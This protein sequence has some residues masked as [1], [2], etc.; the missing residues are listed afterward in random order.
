MTDKPSQSSGLAAA[1]SEEQRSSRI[2]GAL[3]DA[4]SGPFG[5]P[6]GA[7]A[8]ASVLE[9]ATALEYPSGT[10]VP[11]VSPHAPAGEYVGQ[12]TD[13]CLRHRGGLDTLA[14]ALGLLRENSPAARKLRLL[15]DQDAA[16]EVLPLEEL[17]E[18]EELL[19]QLPSRD[20]QAV[21]H[22]ALYAS[23]APL[24]AYCDTPWQTLLH[25]LRRNAL[26]TGLPAYMAFLEYL[27]AG[28]QSAAAQHIRDMNTSRAGQWR[29][30]EQ[31]EHCRNTAEPVSG[32]QRPPRV[33][34]ALMPDGLQDS[35]YILRAWH[36]RFGDETAGLLREPDVT[37]REE[38]IPSE[39][40]SRLRRLSQSSDSGPPVQVEFW[41]PMA[42]MNHRVEEWCRA[43]F[44][45]A[46]EPQCTVV[47]RSLDRARTADWRSRWQHRW[48]RFSQGTVEVEVLS[49]TSDP[50]AP[51]TSASVMVL[52]TPP[53]AE[54]GR[55]ELKRALEIGVPAVLWDRNDCAA[56]EFRHGVKELVQQSTLAELQERLNALRLAGNTS[57]WSSN[58][59][60]LWDDPNHPLPASAPLQDPAGAFLV[61]RGEGRR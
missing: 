16:A 21:A 35:H 1:W 25:L 27:T 41:L 18:L 37:V 3:V 38:A 49:E 58:L 31:L 56:P 39:V 22:A 17:D 50:A 23:P 43:P 60:L 45:S 40:Y 12:V 57:A 26:P 34:F 59:T 44:P 5:S 13:F 55:R 10:A 20:V 54:R 52:S 36:D 28:S 8:L 32:S 2:R 30:L 53:D 61:G 24:P 14:E 47:V 15:A 6:A 4:L 9:H 11:D 48:P 51:E 46:T 7:R 42:L 19:G 29:L 33:M